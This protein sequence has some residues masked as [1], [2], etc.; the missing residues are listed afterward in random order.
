MRSTKQSLHVVRD[1]CLKAWRHVAMRI[2]RERD[3]AVAE[4]LLNDLRMHAPTKQMSRCRVTQV[5]N[6][7]AWQACLIEDPVEPFDGPGTVD[8]PTP[9]AS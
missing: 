2:E 1:L 8:R 7:D 6:P 4:E 5:M 9:W 3:S